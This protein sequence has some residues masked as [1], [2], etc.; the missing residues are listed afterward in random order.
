MR[1][2]LRGTAFLEAFEQ[3]LEKYGHRGLHEYDWS[4]PRYHEDPTP[5]LRAIRGHLEAGPA[6]RAGASVTGQQ[7]AAADAMA[8]FEQ[9]LSTWQR[10]T[11]L[12]QGSR[13]GPQDQAGTTCGAS[14]CDRIWSA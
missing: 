1:V 3:F 10:W 8:A 12:A 6:T 5:L 13:L 7:R 14:R 2:V 9:R 11:T 4:L